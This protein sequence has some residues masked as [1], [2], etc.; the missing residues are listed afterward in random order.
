[1]CRLKLKSLALWPNQRLKM[2]TL[3]GR[4][5]HQTVIEKMKTNNKKKPKATNLT[6]YNG[7]SKTKY[8]CY[9]NKQEW[10]ILSKNR[11]Q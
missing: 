10:I 1:M 6:K 5:A 3:F 4:S 11:S 7:K 2:I 8:I 9:H